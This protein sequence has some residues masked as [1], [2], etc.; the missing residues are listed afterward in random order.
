LQNY[1]SLGVEEQF[2]LV[3]PA[4]LFA[5]MLLGRTRGRHRRSS[6]DPRRWTAIGSLAV[7]GI[8]SFW[9]CVSLT[10]S[11]QPWAFFSLPT[12]AWELALGGL[13]ALAAPY[14]RRAPA[15]V[16]WAIG[17][18][19]LGA[20]AWSLAAFGPQT[21][22]PGPAAL[23]P[24]AGTGAALVAGTRELSTGPARLLGLTALQPIGA[25][26]YTWYLWH[27]PLLVLAPAAVGHSLDLAQNVGVCL[28]SLVLATLTTALLEQPVKNST[29]L[30]ARAGRGLAVGGAS[31]LA[32][33]LGAVVLV[34]GLPAP[35]GSGRAA[36]A[37]LVTAPATVN[38]TS[39]TA[40]SPAVT[41]TSLDAQVNQQVQQSLN[42]PDVP[43]NLTPS[44]ADAAGD[45]PAPE[46][47]GCFDNFT[48]T[49]VNSCLYGD[50]T[51]SRT[52]VLFGDSH[53]LQWFPALDNLANQQHDALV[54]MAKATCPPIDIT[55]FSSDLG[56]TYTE[57][58]EW[59]TA[60]LQRMTALHPAVVILGFSREYGIPD[61]HVV[62]DGPAWLSGLTQVITTVKQ[63]TGAR[64]VLMGDD[65]Y[66]QQNTPDCLSNNLADT[67]VCSIPRRY[68]FYNPG[69][70]AQEK[71]LA[72]SAGAG[73]V[74]TD[75]WFCIS[76]TC[77]V[78]VG[79]ILVYRDDNHITATYADWLTPVIGATLAAATDGAF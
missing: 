42:D 4:L 28:L 75:P 20:V 79:N 41:A 62:V 70:I 13:L 76:T 65:P 78:I 11:D 29:W 34:A 71:N 60:E 24:V 74:D 8:L 31:S 16:L 14:L 5:A 67:P 43:S 36:A 72:A 6:S 49:S 32:A 61:D 33:A 64:V 1:W 57:C 26:S 27:W 47:D 54:V 12:R 50:T 25:V 21:P 48:D 56:H 55:V 40:P 10:R 77:T 35:V 17:W 22:F 38:R 45:V 30:R 39:V 23:V 69:G 9:L 7:L 58:S 44:L 52:V 15:S 37:R 63:T 3:W 68:P 18:A 73:Y 46:D 59:R 19:G 2:Y 51:S 53:A 66:P